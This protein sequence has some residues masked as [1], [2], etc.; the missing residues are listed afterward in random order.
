MHTTCSGKVTIIDDTLGA[1]IYPTPP[2]GREDT[3]FHFSDVETE[4]RSKRRFQSKKGRRGPPVPGFRG[5]TW[6]LLSH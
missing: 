1:L 2:G 4:A 3:Y 6:G 5:V